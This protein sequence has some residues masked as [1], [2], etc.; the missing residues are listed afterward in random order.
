MAAIDL[1]LQN[2]RSR[3][4]RQVTRLEE[5]CDARPRGALVLK[6]RGLREYAYVIRRDEGRVVTQYVGKA[7]CWKSQAIGAKLSERRRYENE[8]AQARNELERICKMLRAGG[9]LFDWICR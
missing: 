4:Q 2:E 7:G 5:E 6:K 9:T 3:L 1:Y 8:L